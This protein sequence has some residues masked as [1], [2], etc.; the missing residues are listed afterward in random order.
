MLKFNDKV[1][2]LTAGQTEHCLSRYNAWHLQE[3]Y[4]EILFFPLHCAMHHE[5]PHRL[6]EVPL[7][8]PR[9]FPKASPERQA[10][11]TTLPSGPAT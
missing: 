2:R 1:Q 3:K 6:P 5:I 10:R 4:P 8:E 11:T 9:F 7:A